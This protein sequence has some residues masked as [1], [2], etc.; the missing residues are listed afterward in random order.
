MFTVYKRWQQ[1]HVNVYKI[2]D[3]MGEILVESFYASELARVNKDNTE[4]YHMDKELDEKLENGQK[5]VTVKW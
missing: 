1:H 3:C 5:Y 4:L 2:K